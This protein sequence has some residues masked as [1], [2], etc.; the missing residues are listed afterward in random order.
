MIKDNPIFKIK[1]LKAERKKKA[2]IKDIEFY[3][4]LKSL[5]TTKYCEY[6]DYIIIQ[7]VFDTGMRIGETL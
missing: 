5:D 1:F 2:F 4:L 7:L 6:R 3:K